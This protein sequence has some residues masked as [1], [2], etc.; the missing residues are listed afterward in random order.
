MIGVI[1]ILNLINGSHAAALDRP[2]RHQTGEFKVS[3]SERVTLICQDHSM[4]PTGLK[5]ETALCKVVLKDKSGSSYTAVLPS[6]LCSHKIGSKIK[7][8]LTEEFCDVIAPLECYGNGKP[9]YETYKD[10]GS[11]ACIIGAGWLADPV[12][13][14]V[15]SK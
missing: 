11:L 10:P 3:S 13:N 14:K 7:L 6:A 4:K 9:I 2:V 12:L 8:Q 5:F 1:L 15:S